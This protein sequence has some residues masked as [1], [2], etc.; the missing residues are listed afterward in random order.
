[1]WLYAKMTYDDDPEAFDSSNRGTPVV[2]PQATVCISGTA[3][4]KD[5]C[6]IMD[7]F[8][9]FP[10]IPHD[11]EG[12][13]EDE[14]DR[15]QG[16]PGHIPDF[17]HNMVAALPPWMTPTSIL[18]SGIRVRTWY[19]HHELLVRNEQPRVVQLSAHRTQWIQQMSAVWNDVIILDVPTAFTMPIPMPARGP[20]DQFIALDVILSQGL[21]L[22]R[23]S[24]LVTVHHIDD[25]DGLGSRT[26]A[27]SFPPFVSGF[28]ILD[29]AQVRHI[30]AHPG[31]RVCHIFHGWNAIHVDDTALHRMRPGHSFMIQVP[32]DPNLDSVPTNAAAETGS[33]VASHGLPTDGAEDHFAA[34]QGSHDNE[35]DEDDHQPSEPPSADIDPIAGPLFN[36]HFYRLRRPPLHMFMK[37]AAGVPMLTE[38]A[39]NL[40]VVPASLLQAHAILAPM[41]GD[42]R[43]DFSFIIQSITDLP[44]ASSDALVVIDV[45]LHFHTTASGMQP[46][47]AATRRVHRV[48]R[49]LSRTGVLHYAGVRQYCEW[50]DDA[51]LVDYNNVP[52]DL[53]HPAPKL[54]RHGTYLHVT[55]PPPAQP[56]NTLNAIHVAEHPVINQPGVHDQ[57]PAPAPSAPA[58]SPPVASGSTRR[59]TRAAQTE[60]WLDQLSQLYDEETMIEFEDEGKILYVWTWF[61]HHD[62][63]KKCGAPQIVKLDAFRHL[64]FQDL[65]D[66]WQELIHPEDPIA[67]AVIGHRPPH[68]T[69]TID[70]VHLMIEQQPRESRAAGV[71]SA[72][73]HGQHEDRILQAAYS[74]PRWLCVEDIVDILE[75]NHICEVQVCTA[76]S[77]VAHFQRFIRHDIPS[78]ISIELHV[79]QPGC[80]E[81]PRA[82]SSSEPFQ[83]RRLM[84]TGAHSLLQQSTTVVHQQALGAQGRHLMQLQR[85][86]HRHR[87]QPRDSPLDVPSEHISDEF[88]QVPHRVA[89]C[90]SSPT[91]L[92]PTMVPMWPTEWTTLSD[93]WT[94]YFNQAA[95]PEGISIVA[96]V[97]YSDHNRRTWSENGHAVTLDSDFTQWVPR[98][99]DAWPDWYLPDLPYDIIVARPTPLGGNDGVQFHVLLLQQP[100]PD[101]KTILLSVMDDYTD[102]TDPWVPGLISVV[103]PNIIDHWVLL[104]H[105]IVEFQC[106]PRVAT[107]RCFSYLGNTDLSA[108]NLFPAQHGLCFTV[109]VESQDL[110]PIAEHPDGT[111][112]AARFEAESTNLLQLEAKRVHTDERLTDRLV[113]HGCR[114]SVPRVLVLQ[115]L[116]PTPE[117]TTIMTAVRLH[118]GIHEMQVPEYIEVPSPCTSQV[119]EEELKHWG[120]HCDAIQFGIQER[121][122]CLP[123]G[124]N[125]GEEDCTYMFSNDD[126][127]DMQGCFLH[128]QS[129]AV[130]MHGVLRLLDSLGYA[131]A[132]VIEDVRY[133]C[134]L[135][136]IRFV[137]T[138]PKQVKD[139]PKARVPTAWPSREDFV[140][141]ETKLYNLQPATIDTPKHSVETGFDVQDL[142]ELIAA[143]NF[144]NTG[145]EKLDLPDFI[146]DKVRQ[147]RR[148]Q[149]YDRWLIYTD[150]SS[151]SAL[152]R[153]APERADDLGKP[154]TW[155][156][157]VLGE[158]YMP[159]GDSLIEP[160]GWCAHPVRY[161]PTGSSFTH[162]TRVGAE[163]AERDALIW[164]GI[165]RQSQ[166]SITPTVFCCDSLTCGK[167]A[168]G[169]IGT[170]NADPSYRLQRSI[171]QALEHGLP[172]GHLRLHHVLSHAGDPYN[173]FVDLV[174]KR[175]SQQSLHHRRPKLNMQKWNE[176]FPHFWLQFAQK[177]GLPSWQNGQMVTSEPS[178]PKSQPARPTSSPSP[179]VQADL[180]LSIASANVLS[181]S[182]GPDGHRGK[183]HYLFEQ[184]KAHGLNVM[185]IQESRAE[186]GVTMSCNVLRICGGHEN[187][188]C[189][190]E[191]W[192]NLDQPIGTQADGKKIHFHKSDFQVVHCD[193]RRLLVKVECNDFGCW[194]FV[195]HGPH[196]GRPTHERNTWWSKTTDTLNSFLDQLPCFWMM[197]A[198][199][200]P[201]EADNCTVF[202][203][204]LRSSRNTDLWR[205]C[206]QTFD[207][208]LPS[209]TCIHQG[210]RDTWTSIDGTSTH[211]LDYVAVPSTWLSSCT[212][213]QVLP[214][215]D[216]ATAQDDHQA[217]GIQL[218]WRELRTMG[219]KT[220][221]RPFIDWAAP[222]IHERL[223][224]SLTGMTV[225]PW[226]TDIEAHESQVRLNFHDAL[227]KVSSKRLPG[228]KKSYITDDIWHD[229]QLMLQCRKQLKRGRALLGRE[230]LV[231]AFKAWS[232][233]SCPVEQEAAFNYGSTLRT[234]MLR[235]MASFVR[236][237][238]NLRLKLKEAKTDLMKR[239]LEGIDANTPASSILKLMREFTG[240][241]NPR[242]RKQ[243]TIPL[244]HRQDGIPCRSPSEALDLW[245]DFFASMEG[246]FRQSQD[247]LREDWLRSLQESPTAQ[248]QVEA[249]QLPTLVDLELAFRRVACHKATG[250]DGIPGEVCHF[251]PEQCAQATF[252]SMWKLILFCHESL[253]HKGGLLV[254]AY[255][256]KGATTSCS[257]YRSLLISS[258]FGKSVHRT[259]R[260]A[261]ASIFESFLQAQQIGG[262]RAMPV[263]YGVHLARAYLRQ[264]KAQS[265]S[266]AIAFLDLKEA[267]YRIFRPICMKSTVTDEDLA[268]LMSRLNMPLDALQTLK[269]ILEGPT[270]LEQAQLPELERRSLKAVHLQTHFWMHRQKDVVQTAHGT[271]PGDPFADIV[272][273]Y[274]W[275][276]VLRKLQSFMKDHELIS[277]FPRWPH[278]QLFADSNREP[279]GTED[280]MGPTWMDDLAVCVE[281]STAAGTVT[282]MGLVMSKLLELCLEHCMTPN[283][284]KN[285]TEV[286]FSFR[287]ANSR[288][289]KK[290]YY[291]PQATGSLP[292][293]SEYGVYEVPITASYC[294]LGGILHHSTDQKAEIKKRVGIAFA[295]INHHSKLLFRN[296]RLPLQKRTQLFE[297]LVLSK[298]LYGAET[299]VASD[300]ATVDHFNAAVIKMYRRLLPLP[301]DQHLTDDAILAEVSMPS[302]IELVRRARL[303]YVAT[304]FHCGHRREW[305][306][307]AQD[308]AWTAL[309][310]DD[311]VW[312]WSQ[313]WHSSSLPDPRVDWGTWQ[314]LIVHHRSY[315]RRI[316]R[317]SLR[318]CSPAT[319]EAM[320]GPPFSFGNGGHL[321][322]SI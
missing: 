214:D 162:A 137:N 175:E 321:S 318:T 31:G 78:A 49:H 24:G 218:C 89:A 38:L 130:D 317:Q 198:N 9:H 194:F 18:S 140:W 280:F 202:Q 286:L 203:N 121:F 95:M 267:F 19:I 83:M 254:Q 290:L 215:L 170:S 298:L 245:I 65:T 149:A 61:I 131:R 184:M 68:A 199:A 23:L 7:G 62:H 233:C 109:V 311:M 196:S 144:L 262:R 243:A 37:N 188:S 141:H 197:D 309:V 176:I 307:L 132:V 169:M 209:T 100:R 138:E 77:G 70:T 183:L 235:I 127:T 93:V 291:G 171:F 257:S 42:C 134:K 212:W 11:P 159:E 294:H 41:V 139:K 50:Q 229:R 105:A 80:H 293:I 154:D 33:S 205:S 148:C 26:S 259:L 302:P 177:S 142:Q 124:F 187:K 167:Q 125:Y 64:W 250:P 126:P 48:P 88:Q 14:P 234:G 86:W 216:L 200:E 21:H 145:F 104:Q 322:R 122:L 181:L 143:G 220:Q 164:A 308:A 251:A 231:A 108:G 247:A 67:I 185:G 186:E 22:Q 242:K 285:K 151:Q 72:V 174:A 296:W 264:A 84:P 99:L 178:L 53:R 17:T 244:V 101:H 258:H 228:P 299:W 158:K 73:F 28:H 287:G 60:H 3:P 166:D 150:G 172:H 182:R 226:H 44:A 189:G 119:V 8:T 69:T 315:W 156:I 45:E 217:V 230:C 210:T 128:R 295:A 94:F 81:D 227:R 269:M 306:L 272:F 106:P 219:E 66:P 153:M 275:A 284:N 113:A 253:M 147:E 57:V 30:C 146:R 288:H 36:C 265:R 118:S 256:G 136:R 192:V 278:I 15:E 59:T 29:A 239:R 297:S 10:Q 27:A 98:I 168:F 249:K 279:S 25:M 5:E 211:C 76:I 39:R 201:G 191:L 163:V 316:V 314:D 55:V 34:G 51:C 13:H 123:K 110:G 152:R 277:A 241:T 135:R 195:G 179:A 301:A 111:E 208:C 236:H 303:R 35:Q 319:S 282:N 246:G 74:L 102:P 92:L 266:C 117:H 225:P 271:R 6:S 82:S 54:M 221:A 223:R 222:G 320:V 20:D 43:D 300:N 120:L 97:W 133:P 16:N 87:T 270:A 160:I 173:E 237:R 263:T 313:V 248:F 238:L 40:E 71:L 193:P 310:E 4:G 273:S 107:A 240:P 274:V 46:L 2:D 75:I 63:H 96:E 157:L 289:Y 161:D 103:V 1:M 190:V 58:P 305:G 90:A 260:S 12:H 155:A 56:L 268:K 312:V 255:K 91:P 165:W 52:W 79:R 276:V 252:A 232:H 32:H 283:L 180:S 292:V 207:M 112:E 213:S 85:R 116:I 224:S 47:P 129:E 261:Q 114:P 304:L 281:S 115:D 206:L 204:G